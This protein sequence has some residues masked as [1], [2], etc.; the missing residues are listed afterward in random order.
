[1]SSNYIRRDEALDELWKNTVDT[2]IN[3]S[4]YEDIKVVVKGENIPKP[5]E[6]FSDAGF[7]PLLK[8]NI[9][10]AKYSSPTPVQKYAI[11]IIKEERD[12]MACAQTGSGKTAAFLFPMLD[13]L[14]REKPSGKSS[15]GTFRVTPQVVIM[16][17]TRELVTQTYDEARKFSGGSEV[18]VANV[19]GGTNVPQQLQ[20]LERGCN[21]LVATP[22][23][24]QDFLE[25]GRISFE[26]VQYL[27]LDEADRMLDMGF[28]KQIELCIHHKTMTR[29]RVTLMFSATFPHQIQLCA[30]DYL[31]KSHL[32]LQ[33]GIVGGA[34]S[35]VR[36]TFHDASAMSRGEK[37]DKLVEMLTE[38]DSNHH[39]TLIFVE[40]KKLADVV[41]GRLSDE[42]KMSATSMHGDRSQE[43][44][45]M[46]LQDFRR[47]KHPILVAT[48]V[49]ARGLDINDIRHVINFE[50]PKEAEEYVHR[51][52][53]TG[54]VGNTGR[55]TSFVDTRNDSG[56]IPQLVKILQDA[57]Q[58]VPDWMAGGGGYGRGGGSGFEWS[59]KGGRGGRF[60]DFGNG[61]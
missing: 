49:A 47:G 60:N 36:Q 5:I 46:A 31:N 42:E 55:A 11:S 7:S 43:Q 34:C 35:D 26:S 52:G 27:V 19:Y 3:F 20:A 50:M 38:M 1:M 24:L 37:M 23:R 51:I 56:V 13:R 41:A 17:P 12:L 6:K 22:G 53:R 45:E 28:K 40:T 8:S 32:F 18:L 57:G 61:Y 15:H 2:G 21:V 58:P 4:K 54:R 39:R 30:R 25:R 48:S 44:R 14:M 33:V 29:D 9:Q 16:A 10:R 59:G